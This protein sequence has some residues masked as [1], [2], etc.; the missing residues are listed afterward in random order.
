MVKIYVSVV[1]ELSVNWDVLPQVIS[2]TYLEKIP[3]AFH[4][5]VKYLMPLISS[6]YFKVLAL[7]N[8]RF[9]TVTLIC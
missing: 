6:V 5:K 7:D 8:I 4:I 2:F 1:F 3:V 9:D